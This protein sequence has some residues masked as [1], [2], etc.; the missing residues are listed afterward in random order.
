[1]VLLAK[2]R[3]QFSLISVIGKESYLVLIQGSREGEEQISVLE[4]V[5]RKQ[6]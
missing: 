2:E 5:P 3:Y 6:S 1:M 4:L